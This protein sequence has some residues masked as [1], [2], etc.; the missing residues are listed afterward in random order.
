MH[1]CSAVR[2]N[3]GCKVANPMQSYCLQTVSLPR[4]WANLINEQGSGLACNHTDLQG[5]APEPSCTLTGLQEKPPG[6]GCQIASTEAELKTEVNTVSYSL[7]SSQL[8]LVTTPF[9]SIL[10][11]IEKQTKIPTTSLSKF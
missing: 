4:S 3:I 9:H 10:L 6:L 7:V 5:G 2:Q 1:E 11:F 8:G